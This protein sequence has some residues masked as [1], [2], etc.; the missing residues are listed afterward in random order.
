M[1]TT[2]PVTLT[3]QLSCNACCRGTKNSPS[4]VTCLKQSISDRTVKCYRQSS[5]QPTDVVIGDLDVVRKLGVEGMVRKP[6]SPVKLESVDC[7][8][9]MGSM[10]KTGNKTGNKAGSLKKG[11]SGG[12]RKRGG[13]GGVESLDSIFNGIQ[14]EVERSVLLCDTVLGKLGE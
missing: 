13:G 4:C 5:D 1:T 11:G 2:Q 12:R 6:V 14:L 10:K 8:K 3:T 9:R 7:G